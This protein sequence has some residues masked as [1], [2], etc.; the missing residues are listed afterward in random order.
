MVIGLGLISL[1]LASSTLAALNQGPAVR[2]DNAVCR[3]LVTS[4]LWILTHL[5]TRRT[6][7]VRPTE[8]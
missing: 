4:I 8:A 1:A 5:V 6:S 2:L 7:S 3:C